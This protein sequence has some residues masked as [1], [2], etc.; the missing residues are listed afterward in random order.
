MQDSLEEFKQ[1]QSS[2]AMWLVGALALFITSF[3]AAT[4]APFSKRVTFLYHTLPPFVLAVLA[5]GTVLTLGKK[6]TCRPQLKP[7]LV[8]PWLPPVSTAASST[9]KTA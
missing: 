9:K 3:C 6:A 7:H 4:L 1:G 2:G 8:Q 5:I